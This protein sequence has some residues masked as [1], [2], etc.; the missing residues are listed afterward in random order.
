M[1]T[2]PCTKAGVHAAPAP[3][4]VEAVKRLGGGELW[5]RKESEVQAGAGV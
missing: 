2:E 1:E 3:D 4:T 5:K